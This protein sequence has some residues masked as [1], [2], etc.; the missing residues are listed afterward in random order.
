MWKR[1]K[2]GPAVRTEFKKGKSINMW[3]AIGIRG[4]TWPVFFTGTM[5][6]SHYIECLGEKVIPLRSS[7]STHPTTYLHN[8]ASYHKSQQTTKFIED[9][10]LDVDQLSPLS[11]DFNTIE[12][13]WWMVEYCVNEQQP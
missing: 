5:D 4:R 2:D 12:R 11:P 10:Q 8:N 3:A 13:I 1:G 7:I 9:N 6:S